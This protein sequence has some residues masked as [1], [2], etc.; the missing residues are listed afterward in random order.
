MPNVHETSHLPETGNFRP[1]KSK[2]MWSVNKFSARFFSTCPGLKTIKVLTTTIKT[3]R[4][5]LKLRSIS[6]RWLLNVADFRLSCERKTC[7]VVVYATLSA[8]RIIRNCQW[9]W[10]A[11]DKTSQNDIVI[12]LHLKSFIIN[13]PSVSCWVIALISQ[14]DARFHSEGIQWKTRNGQQL[15]LHRH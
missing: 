14:T 9:D 12:E 8:S 13:Y 10:N 3:C 4:K 5:V 2:R 15:N 1:E 11:F 6:D 7:C